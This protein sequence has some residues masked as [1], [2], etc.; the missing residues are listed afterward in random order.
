M[1]INDSK[2]LL[3]ISLA[4]GVTLVAIMLAWAIFYLAMILRQIRKLTTDIRLKVEA[5]DRVITKVGEKISDMSSVGKMVV[6]TARLA[7]DAYMVNQDHGKK[8][9]R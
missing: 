6:D 4:F 5:V 8:K 2:D 9:K 1:L 7:A 3:N